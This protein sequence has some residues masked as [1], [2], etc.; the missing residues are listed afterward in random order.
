M[1]H[2]LLQRLFL[3]TLAMLAW[4]GFSAPD[5]ASPE[6]AQAMATLQFRPSADKA[7]ACKH[8]AV[9]GTAEAVA[10]LPLLHVEQLAAWARTVGNDSRTGGSGAARRAG[11]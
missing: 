4:H 10:A 3:L 9:Y 2:H 7:L 5:P 6:K 11:S 1:K 8:L